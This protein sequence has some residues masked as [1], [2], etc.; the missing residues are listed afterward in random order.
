MGFGPPLEADRVAATRETLRRE[1]VAKKDELRREIV[2]KK[3]RLAAVEQVR[4]QVRRF[5]PTRPVF[6][7][8]PLSNCPLPPTEQSPVVAAAKCKVRDVGLLLLVSQKEADSTESFSETC[9]K[10]T[11]CGEG[12]GARPARRGVRHW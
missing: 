9:G 3:A 8:P 11:I 6:F 5:L 4:E 1:I 10:R 7:F 2:S 12:R